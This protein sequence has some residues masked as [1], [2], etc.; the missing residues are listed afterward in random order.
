MTAAGAEV[1]VNAE[2]EVEDGQPGD[3]AACPSARARWRAAAG[4]K[5]SSPR[6]S[7]GAADAVWSKAS[8]AERVTDRVWTG[9]G[10]PGPVAA[11]CCLPGGGGE[12]A[13]A[14]RL[15]RLPLR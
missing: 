2:A 15:L 9:S 1:R 11:G 13:H 8:F 5:V 7:V 4:A 14:G 6:I 3:R 12:A 10:G